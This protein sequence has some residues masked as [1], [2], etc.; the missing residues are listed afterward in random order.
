MLIVPSAAAHAATAA[1]PAASDAFPPSAFFKKNVAARVLL[2]SVRVAAVQ[3]LHAPHLQDVVLLQFIN[4]T[5]APIRLHFPC[6]P[7]SASEPSGRCGA[8]ELSLWA[9]SKA[10][11]ERACVFLTAAEAGESELTPELLQQQRASAVW[12]HAAPQADDEP[13]A[14]VGV[15]A[16]SLATVT[17]QF[18]AAWSLAD[19]FALA[20]SVEFP[21]DT[22]TEAGGSL[23]AAAAWSATGGQLPVRFVIPRARDDD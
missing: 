13:D 11:R 3:T 18:C 4:P 19:A 8:A 14:A 23:T 12:L 2:P 21:R 5:S 16:R 15:A 20:V 6:A 9:L 22:L 7:Q 1:A 10:P 17:I